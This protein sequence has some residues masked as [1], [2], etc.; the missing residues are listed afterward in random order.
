MNTTE[1]ASPA[2]ALTIGF[3]LDMTLADGRPGIKAVLDMVAAETGVTIDSDLAITRV[4]PPIEEELAN[5]FP[6]DEVD[7][8]ADRYRALFPQYGAPVGELLPG[9]LEAIAAVHRHGGRTIVVTGKFEPNARLNLAALGIKVDDVFGSV[10][11]DRKGA[12][13]REQ[14]ASVYVGDHLGDITG[15]RAGGA[16]AVT[17]AT[18]PFT[19][20]QLREAG[21]DVVLKD[22]TEFPGW[23]DAHLAG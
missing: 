11:A 21:A 3:D 16:L 9:A 14:G 17:V 22:L 18:G 12:V 6:A 8:A 2:P 10:F 1:N 19:A 20:D 4:G 13:L 7:A 23:L 5:W 15:A